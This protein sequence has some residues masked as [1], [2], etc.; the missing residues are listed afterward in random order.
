MKK[1]I[2]AIAI[3]FALLTGSAYAV[4]KLSVPQGGTGVSSVTSGSYLKGAGAGALV[5]RTPAEVK[6]DLD[7]SGTN[8]GDQDLS[9]YMQDGDIDTFAKL[10]SWAVGYT[11]NNTNASTICASGS[12]LN[13]DGTCN[14]GYLD[15]DGTDSTNDSVQASELALDYGDFTCDGTTCSLDSSYQ[16]L[17]STLTDIADGTIAENLVNTTYPWA[18]DEVSNDLTITN[19]SGVN[20]GDQ[21][22]IS[23]NAATATALAANGANCSTGNYPLGVD[24]SGAVE[25]CTEIPAA[26]VGGLY[27]MNVETLAAD[28]TLT[29]GTDKIYQYLDAGGANRIITLDTASASVGNRF[30]I[31][32]NGAYNDTYYLQINQSTTILDY[33]YVGAIKEFIFDGT[34]WISGSTGSGENITDD[35]KTATISIGKNSKAYSSG[36]AI[37]KDC[38]GYSN[39]MAI[40]NNA[41]GY[42]AGV[43]IGI[44]SDGYDYGAAVGYDADGYNYGA[45]VGYGTD[46]YDY[47]AAVGYHTDGYNYGAAVGYYTSGY[48]HGAAVGY[49]ADGY[50]YGAAVGY[51]ASGYS[52]GAA[53][54]YYARGYD[55]GAAVGYSARGYNHGAAVGYYTGTNQKYYSVALGYYS[56]TER[57]SEIAHCIDGSSTQDYNMSSAGWAI[58][59]ADA[60]PIE[61]PLGETIGQRFTINPE[62]AVSFTIRIAARDNVSNHVASY[63]I[64]GLIKRDGVDNTVLAW[65]NKTVEYEDDATWDVDVTADDTNEALIITVTGDDTN[66]TRF[67]GRIDE[68]ETQF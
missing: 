13:G 50:D 55:H 24:A 38:S 39:G 31:R 8:T 9:A 59:T 49:D 37:G 40:G 51:Y 16:P 15:A 57:Y 2:L 60:T 58:Q 10:Q 6:T 5:E 22:D 29:V 62:S 52:S 14:A 7:L 63:K 66:P 28:K 47:G 53:V 25:S 42:N 3:C 65:S 43:A 30:V 44:S 34:N 19:L 61:M 67:A 64:E 41:S 26:D 20:T 27:G 23:G 32:Y 17:E 11:D 33:V 12:F 18:D 4:T 21:T 36:L 1:I 54:G 45:A 46:G 48:D 68:V 35:Y 56:E